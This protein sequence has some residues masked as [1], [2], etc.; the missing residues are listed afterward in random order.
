MDRRR[1]HRCVADR[2]ADL[3]QAGHQ[4]T[5]SIQA[6]D[7]GH[8]MV[9]DQQV[10]VSIAVCLKVPGKFRARLA[11]EHRIDTVEIERA[12]VADGQMRQ[13]VFVDTDARNQRDPLARDLIGVRPAGPPP[14]IRQSSG[15]SVAA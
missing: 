8:L 13:S 12:T 10:A 1:R 14:M 3:V 15:G 4:V 11:A 7:A 9:I 2:N 6:R 5:G